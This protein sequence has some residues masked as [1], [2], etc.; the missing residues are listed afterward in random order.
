VGPQVTGEQRTTTVSNGQS[1]CRMR[2][3]W[4][5]T[6]R[7]GRSPIRFH[8]AEATGPYRAPAFSRNVRF[9]RDD[10]EGGEGP[11]GVAGVVS[12]SVVNGHQA[13]L[14][15]SGISDPATLENL[16]CLIGQ[17]EYRRA[18]R[19]PGQGLGQRHHHRRR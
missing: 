14:L 17:A 4:T 11:G 19:Q 1:S 7:P 5:H 2:W 10:P 18:L 13:K 3:L 6:P 8:T 12:D 9:I 15:L 16:S